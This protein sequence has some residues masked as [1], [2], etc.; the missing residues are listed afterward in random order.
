MPMFMGLERD[1]V[2]HFA[3]RGCTAMVPIANIAA[4]VLLANSKFPGASL[5]FAV[6]MALSFAVARIERGLTTA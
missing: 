1:D 6:A 4:G 3:R 2:L 5:A